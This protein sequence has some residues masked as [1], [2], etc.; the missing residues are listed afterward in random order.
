ME[1]VSK[2]GDVQHTPMSPPPRQSARSFG[3][4]IGAVCGLMA[5]FSFWRGHDM[6]AWGWTAVSIALLAPAFLYPSLLRVPSAVW[7]RFA[8]ALGWVNARVLLSAF[9]FLVLTPLGL[10]M[11]LGG[12]DPMQRRRGRSTGWFPYP[13]RVRSAKH[14]D[15]MY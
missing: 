10:A 7:W 15:R 2:Y 14:Y 12:W 5:A 13:E 8:R 4:S 9:F 1:N 6:R 3:F 11:R